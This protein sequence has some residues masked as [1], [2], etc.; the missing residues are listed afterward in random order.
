VSVDRLGVFLHYH[1]VRAI[2]HG[3]PGHDARTI[4]GA[5]N[6]GTHR[7][8]GNGVD[9]LQHNVVCVWRDAIITA[10]TVGRM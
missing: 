6:L 5:D 8:G 4:P 9:Y 2:G 3:R 1:R 10:I 7:A